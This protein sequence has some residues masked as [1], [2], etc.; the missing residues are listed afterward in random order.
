LNGAQ[1]DA[2][3]LADELGKQKASQRAQLEA[4]MEKKRAARAQA[5]NGAPAAGPAIVMAVRVRPRSSRERDGAD[6]VSVAMTRSAVTVRDPGPG[7]GTKT[8]EVDMCFNS[9][10]ERGELGRFASQETVYNHFARPLVFRAAAGEPMLLYAYGQRGSGK[11]HTVLGNTGDAAGQGLLPRVAKELCSMGRLA[12]CKFSV[13][14]IEGELVKDAFEQS[15]GNPGLKVRT[16]PGT[17]P[18][19]QGLSH[20]IVS[21]VEDIAVAVNKFEENYAAEG[22]RAVIY[23]FENAAGGPID[24][25]VVDM[26]GSDRAPSAGA[27]AARLKQGTS[28]NLMLSGLLNCVNARKQLAVSPGKKTFIPTRDSSLTNILAPFITAGIV[29]GIHTIGPAPSEYDETLS[30][31]RNAA[32]LTLPRPKTVADREALAQKAAVTV[33]TAAA[34]GAAMRLF[35]KPMPAKPAAAVAKQERAPLR[36][37]EGEAPTDAER[38]KAGL[39]ARL[40]AKRARKRAEIDSRETR[41]DDDAGAAED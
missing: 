22:V 19:P 41:G 28:T 14:V 29:A 39:R 36:G 3:R 11:S 35:R 10:D 18:Y 24:I 16:K 34:V 13:V 33:T 17:G 4:R 23:R 5:V 38:S 30:T 7:G 31:L 15:D 8:M 1:E 32:R 25:A 20:V 27:G 9:L 2:Q 12:E 6:E 37:D 21:C 40:D 26:P